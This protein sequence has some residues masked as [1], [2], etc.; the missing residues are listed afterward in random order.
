VEILVK[1]DDP[2]RQR[3]T[4]GALL[5]W[6]PAWAGMLMFSI[7][8]EAI[9]MQQ[10]ELDNGM[11]II[12]VPDHRS[13]VVLHSVWFRAGSMDEPA[14][15]TG[16]A[17][18]L[19]H[20]MF[21]GTEK[22]KG[23]ERETLV[24]RHGAQ[25]N[26]FTSRDYTAYYQKVAK[27]KLPL[28]MELEAD[29]MAN[30]SLTEKDFLPE[31]DVVSEERRMRTESQ[32]LQRFFEKIIKIHYEGSNYEHPVI[33][34][35]ADIEGY[36]L[37]DAVDWYKTH[38]APNNAT[39]ILVGDITLEEALPLVKDHYGSLR[40]AQTPARAVRPLPVYESPRRLEE[41]DKDVQVPVL[42]RFYRA[43]SAT[44]RIAGEQG[45]LRDVA[46]LS[47]MA[48]ILGGSTTGRLYLDL[49]KKQELAD[50]AYADYDS[51]AALET[52]VEVFLQPKPGVTLIRVEEAADAV[53]EEL[54]T[55]GVTAEELA[56]AKTGLISDDVYARDDPFQ[57]VYRLGIWL[58]AG[59]TPAGFETWVDQ[60]KAVT[61]DD[62]QRVARQYLQRSSS[63]TG[64]LA[65]S[66]E[67][68]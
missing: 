13:P 26:A 66:K 23:K 16:I 68:L 49:V 10:A 58:M 54:V 37:Q 12:V 30:L 25:E 27:E 56:R 2:A 42:M 24:A 18:M 36:K 17:H 28:M 19:E 60:V 5:V 33:G 38:Y 15:K 59:G 61:Q 6:L 48:E 22:L 11:K 4:W 40:P 45:D 52:A 44:A 29:R 9:E 53:I 67:Q 50:S 31:R 32:P 3:R 43:P 34:W 35:R 8:S 1:L 65:A 39:M 47:V 55:G 20:L 14:G 62:V 57:T 64:L 46:A 51:T 7:T 63:T 21:K 41:I